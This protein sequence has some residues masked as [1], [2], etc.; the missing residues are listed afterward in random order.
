[1]AI[2]LL[3]QEELVFEPSW[4]P[5][6]SLLTTHRHLQRAM[7][8]LWHGADFRER[9]TT[10]AS[11]SDLLLR[12][13]LHVPDSLHHG[14]GYI[15]NESKRLSRPSAIFEGHFRRQNVGG[16]A[17]NGN[18]RQCLFSTAH[19]HS[20]SLGLPLLPSSSTGRSSLDCLNSRPE[21]IG[22]AR[23]LI[24]TVAFRRC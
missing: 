2:I 15:S 13:G 6:G 12:Q 10:I 18:H 5:V 24:R 8:K 22:T 11:I 4:R 19:F 3:L 14:S 16:H 1:M 9:F 21:T 20:Y 7:E 23:G 17:C